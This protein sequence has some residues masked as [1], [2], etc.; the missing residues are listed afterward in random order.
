M[1]K[2][3][4]I[5]FTKKGI[6][7]FKPYSNKFKKG[8][9]FP[10]KK[11][12]FPF[13][14]AYIT[15]RVLRMENYLITNINNASFISP[16]NIYWKDFDFSMSI[17]EELKAFLKNK[18]IT[19]RILQQTLCEIYWK[20]SISPDE[21]GKTIYKSI[22]HLKINSSQFCDTVINLFFTCS[23]NEELKEFLDELE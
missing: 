16:Y 9:I 4:N 13:F 3:G 6:F 2:I 7:I 14:I 18:E 23:N 11:E 19:P 15:R 1:K 8:K 22:N 12:I 5:T 20:N 10:A 21:V 17:Y